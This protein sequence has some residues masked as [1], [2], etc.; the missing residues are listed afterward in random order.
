MTQLV[1]TLVNKSD[2]LSLNFHVV[3]G[4]NQFW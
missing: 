2:D 1:K 4:K 3:E